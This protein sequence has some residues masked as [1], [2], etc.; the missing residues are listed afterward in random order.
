MF[1]AHPGYRLNLLPEDRHSLE[2]DR[3]CEP[4]IGVDIL[5]LALVTVREGAEPTVNLASPIVLN[6]KNRKGVQS[7]PECSEYSMQHPLSSAQEVDSCS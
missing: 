5:C 2:L 7:I 3:A 4:Q 6:L 1:V